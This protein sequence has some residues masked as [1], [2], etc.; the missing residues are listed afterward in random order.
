MPFMAFHMALC[1]SAATNIR[2][3]FGPFLP[4]CA[5][6]PFSDLSALENELKGGNVAAFIVEPIQG[7]GV[8]VPAADYLQALPIF[9]AGME[10]C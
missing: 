1:P 10:R 4:G 5:R 2:R 8:N 3:R 9:A 7:K 6:I